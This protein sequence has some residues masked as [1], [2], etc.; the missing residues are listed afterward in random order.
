[1]KHSTENPEAYSLYL[2][3]RYHWNKRNN[4]S[5]RKAIEL[6]KQAI[7]KDPLYALA[8]TGVADSYSLLDQYGTLPLRDSILLARA[9][10]V[11]ALELDDRL[12]EAHTSLAE[13]EMS[14]EWNWS[15]AE[16]RLR[17]AIAL[18]PNYATAHHWLANCLMTTGRFDE[19]FTEMNR[20]L[21]L[22]PLSLIMIRDKGV[23]FYYAR[24]YDHAVRQARRTLDLDANFALAHRLLAIAYE[25]KGK[26]DEAEAELHIWGDL[27]NDQ[28]RTQ[29]ALGHL[30]AVSGNKVAARS[31]LHQLEMDIALRKDL[32]YAV[33]LIYTGLGEIN[34]AFEWLNKAYED[35]SGALGTIKIDPKVDALR[36]DPRFPQILRKMGL[37]K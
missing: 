17:T 30:Y 37:E 19:A 16:R 24:Q 23:L 12:A 1:V 35:R 29:A 25:R 11:K 18:N 10:A 31:I 9:A 34:Q 13:V 27:T 14:Y 33:V 21:E 32:A 36:S 22:D 20:S 4:E 26:Y 28:P 3:G 15:N 7:E 8:Y 6:F 5:L 2:E